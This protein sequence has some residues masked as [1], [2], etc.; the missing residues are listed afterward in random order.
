MG[1]AGRDQDKGH[2]SDRCRQTNR[3]A[4]RSPLFLGRVHL[5]GTL[6]SRPRRVPKLPLLTPF[7]GLGDASQL[8]RNNYSDPQWAEWEFISFS[9][10]RHSSAMDL[11]VKD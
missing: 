1:Q 8:L 9:A 6:A 10:A 2:E 7:P 4:L 3:A 11:F 5:Y